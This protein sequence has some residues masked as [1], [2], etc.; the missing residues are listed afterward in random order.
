MARDWF[1]MML[2]LRGD[3]PQRHYK[4]RHTD[5]QKSGVVDDDRVDA[6]GNCGAFAGEARR[7]LIPAFPPPSDQPLCTT[8]DFRRYQHHGA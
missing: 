6:A 1:T 7:D 5:G 2:L 3:R 4:G 8:R